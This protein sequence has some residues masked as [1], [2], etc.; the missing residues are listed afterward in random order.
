[1]GYIISPLIFVLVMELF[2]R[3]T[4]DTT[5]KKTAP[6]YEGFYGW[7]ECDFRVEIT[8]GKTTETSTKAFQ[9]DSHEDKTF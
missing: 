5:G 2:P 3:S 7:R 4:K 8:Y 6:I 9:V 1:M